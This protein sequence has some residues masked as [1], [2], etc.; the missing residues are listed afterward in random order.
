[1]PKIQIAVKK[2]EVPTIHLDGKDVAENVAGVILTMKP[3]RCLVSLQLQS[4]PTDDD[5]ASAVIGGRFEGEI[6]IEIDELPIG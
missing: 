2:D 5:S 4:D 1:M 6:N 3:G